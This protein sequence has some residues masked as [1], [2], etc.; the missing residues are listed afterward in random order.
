MEEEEGGDRR[1]GGVDT[2]HLMQHKGISCCSIEQPLYSIIIIRI[3][4]S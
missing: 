4:V 1:E 2:V 3:E